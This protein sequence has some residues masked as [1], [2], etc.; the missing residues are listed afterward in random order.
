MK[1]IVIIGGGPA[2]LTTAIN[3]SCDN[4]NVVILERNGEV[5]KK[6]L[7]TGNGRCNYFNE[8]IDSSYYYSNNDE[9]LP[10]IF[11]ENNIML[12]HKFFKEL[13]IETKIKNGYM[14][15]F[16]NKASTIRN[17]LLEEATRRGVEI[18]YNYDVR[19]ISF[20]DN[21]YIINKSIECDYLVIACG[22]K[23][24][25]R[26]GSTGDGEIFANN[27]SLNFV[28]LFPS[29]VKLHS[30]LKT[31][32]WAGVRSD[33]EVSLFIDNKMVKKEAGELQLTKD[34]ISGICVFNIS[35]EA[36]IG[37]SRNRNV[38][39]F[40]N[41]LPF[42]KY[43]ECISY[44]DS[45]AKLTDTITVSSFLS[46]ILNEKLVKAILV[47]SSIKETKTYQDL[48]YEEKV[49]LARNLCKFKLVI[50]ST[51][52]FE[53]AEV[54]SGG[55]SLLELD[56]SSFEVNRYPGLYV[57]GETA[58]VDGICGGYNLGFAWISGILAGSNIRSKS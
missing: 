6:L 12:V 26:T 30:K 31:D 1:K 51:D 13:C 45:K 24:F 20:E 4:N 11:T 29:L 46:R 38:V 10:S 58:D 3:A 52:D 32:A 41:F 7:L 34:G 43:D 28:P 37:L 19:E 15:P 5:G 56:T 14:Y 2:G 53:T 54:T 27:L 42:I 33:A 23:S 39:V 8:D 35:R 25:P 50:N 18:R 57:V 40:I 22:G 36:V 48:S 17:A 9:I 44:L 16:S 49:N 47:E 21:K 55:I